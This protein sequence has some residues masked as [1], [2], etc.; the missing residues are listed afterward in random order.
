MS[1]LIEVLRIQE[2]DYGNEFEIKLKITTPGKRHAIM[3]DLEIKTLKIKRGIPPYGALF[4][5]WKKLEELIN[6][7]TKRT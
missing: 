4:D 5:L 1:R 2:H 6:E 7:P 3:D